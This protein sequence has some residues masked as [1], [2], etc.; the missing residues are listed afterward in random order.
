MSDPTD[1]LAYLEADPQQEPYL[2]I[3]R[4][5]RVDRANLLLADDAVS[6]RDQII[7]DL[8]FQLGTAEE[9]LANY[10]QE[11]VAAVAWIR[12]LVAF[13]HE[14]LPTHLVQQAGLYLEQYPL[15]QHVPQSG[16]QK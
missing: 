2:S 4:A 5:W 13:G 10:S 7:K 9:G 12:V 1:W 15:E 3:A 8:G 11:L 14:P 6:A 16:E